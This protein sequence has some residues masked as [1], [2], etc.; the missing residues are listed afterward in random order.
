M[1]TAE[2]AGKL[3]ETML[4][5]I[6]KTAD[7][8]REITFASN[9]QNTGVGQIS[10]AMAQLNNTTQQNAAG[11]EELSATAEEMNAQTE[12]LLAMVDQFQIGKR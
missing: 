11:S 3:L 10:S 12:Q 9:E 4:P 5:S 6:Q 8:V 1:G 2:Q 7:L